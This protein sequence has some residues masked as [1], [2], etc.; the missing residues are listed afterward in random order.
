MLPCV[1]V[2]CWVAER[3]SRKI[4][5]STLKVAPVGGSN[6]LLGVLH[7]AQLKLANHAG[8]INDLVAFAGWGSNPPVRYG[9]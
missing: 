8:C 7:S 4:E 1:A 9:A 5:Q 3:A 2:V 6:R